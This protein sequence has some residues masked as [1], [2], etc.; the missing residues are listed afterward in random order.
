MR[1]GALAYSDRVRPSSMSRLC[2]RRP[3]ASTKAPVTSSIQTARPVNGSSP[4]SAE[5]AASGPAP[6]G[7]LGPEPSGVLG[8]EPSGVPTDA[9]P[10]AASVSASGAWPPL[11]LSC[12]RPVGGGPP[13]PPPP[14]ATTTTTRAA[15][16]SGLIVALAQHPHGGV[17]PHGSHLGGAGGV[18]DP[19]GAAL[20]PGLAPVF[21][22]ACEAHRGVGVHRPDLGGA[23]GAGGGLPA[24]RAARSGGLIVALAQHPHG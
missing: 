16:S 8:P 7:V 21:A 15:P 9:R 17:Y 13:G 10:P 2:N 1:A 19:L 14:P 23:L 24:R 5:A 18:I 12:V 20:G 4:C 6:L 3:L 11:L 22:V